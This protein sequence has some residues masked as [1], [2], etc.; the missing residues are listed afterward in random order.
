M[1]TAKKKIVAQTQVPDEVSLLK[2]K[3]SEK[4][5]TKVQ[6]TYGNGGKGKIS[7]PFGSDE[8]LKRI[9]NIIH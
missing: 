1:Q 2:E 9:L 5:Q 3:L 7:I 4:L 8:E 6:V